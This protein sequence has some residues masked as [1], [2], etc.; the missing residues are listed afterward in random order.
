[1]DPRTIGSYGGPKLDSLPV[2]NP[3]TQVAASEMNRYMEDLAQ[4]TRTVLRA[5]ATFLTSSAAPAILPAGSVTHRSVWGSGSGQQPVVEK[6]GAGLYTITYDPSFTD[7][8]GTV[9]A[10]AFY[11]GHASCMSANSG[12]IVTARALTVAANVVT[13]GVY[14]AGALSDVG[15][16]SGLVFPVTVWLL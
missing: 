9:E 13:V 7:P 3:E 5:A 1:M 8:L 14:A 6:T 10:V 4:T 11:A 16:I 2:S 15:N 12:D